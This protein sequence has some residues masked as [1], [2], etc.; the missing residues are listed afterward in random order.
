MLNASKLSECTVK[1]GEHG[2]P[3]FTTVKEK[4]LKH[5]SVPHLSIQKPLGSG[6][7]IPGR[8][9]SRLPAAGSPTEPELPALPP[10]VPTT[11]TTG[12]V[13]PGRS[14]APASCPVFG[15]ED[16]RLRGTRSHHWRRSSLPRTVSP[17]PLFCGFRGLS[18]C[19]S[20]S[21][22]TCGFSTALKASLCLVPSLKK[23]KQTLHA[24]DAQ[25]RATV[26]TG[27]TS[28]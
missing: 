8:A 11:T 26:V 12:W 22:C 7:V 18:S 4:K 13:A 1:H 6:P 15:G 10:A 16:A 23:D 21:L 5:K 25:L 27:L 2:K 20:S 14:S 3:H 9:P 24:P 19:K 28:S 17:F